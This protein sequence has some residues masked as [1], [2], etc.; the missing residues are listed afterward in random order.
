MGGKKIKE[1]RVRKRF[2]EIVKEERARGRRYEEIALE[3]GISIDTMRKFMY[4]SKRN[5]SELT[6]RKIKNWMDKTKKGEVGY[7]EGDG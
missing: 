3:I 5:V 1:A 6:L 2:L 4:N 7:E